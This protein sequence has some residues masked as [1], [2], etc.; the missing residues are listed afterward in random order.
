[1][2]L[3]ERGAII[4]AL[5]RTSGAEIIDDAAGTV[6]TAPHRRFLSWPQPF[7]SRSIGRSFELNFRGPQTIN[8]AT[9]VDWGPFCDVNYSQRCGNCR[10]D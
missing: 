9:I 6:V 4:M 2:P 3:R 5:E 8:P 7:R 1:M 10:S